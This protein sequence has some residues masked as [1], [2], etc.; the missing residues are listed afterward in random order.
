M[1]SFMPKFLPVAVFWS[2]ALLKKNNAIEN[3]IFPRRPRGRGHPWPA[4]PDLESFPKYR[5]SSAFRDPDQ[6]Q[7]FC[8]SGLHRSGVDSDQISLIYGGH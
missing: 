6:H 2:S 3:I 1:I 4:L 8:R 5:T 7:C